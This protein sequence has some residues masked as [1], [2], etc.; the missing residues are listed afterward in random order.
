V[1]NLS[2]AKKL[3]AGGPASPEENLQR[4]LGRRGQA[5]ISEA[6]E[7]QDAA[8]VQMLSGTCNACNR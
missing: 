5:P 4:F 1:V 2:S 8:D 6:E 3:E 7:G